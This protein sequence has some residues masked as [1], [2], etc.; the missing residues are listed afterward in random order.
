MARK[1]SCLKFRC[2]RRDTSEATE[3]LKLN[4]VEK[5]A[6]DLRE[7]KNEPGHDWQV[8]CKEK[9][10]AIEIGYPSHADLLEQTFLAHS[11][12]SKPHGTALRG[13]RQVHG[14]NRPVV[15]RTSP[16]THRLR[17]RRDGPD[18]PIPVEVTVNLVNDDV[19][20]S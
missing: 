2:N 20:L 13:W 14:K 9:E 3:K 11:L 10:Y 5:S 18:E 19:H 4:A 16:L 8:Y 12:L 17:E 6:N 15:T 1:D 7:K